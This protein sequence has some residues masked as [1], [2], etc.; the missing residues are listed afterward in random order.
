[1][2][3]EFDFIKKIRKQ[4]AIRWSQSA[5]IFGVG[6]DAAVFRKDSKTDFVITTDLLVENIDFRLE[7]T[8]PEYLGHKAL[9]V[10]LS[11]IAAMG[12]RPCFALLSIGV[13]KN[14]WKT[15]FLD[16]FY[17]GWFA[18]AEKY[19]VQLI[20]GDVSKTPDKIVVDSIVIGE[21][22]RGK[23][24]LRSTANAGDLIFVTGALGGAAAGLAEIRSPTVK[25][26]VNDRATIKER[27]L[28]QRQL[29]PNAQVEIGALLGERN[30][31]TSMIDISD[32]LSS[33]LNHLCE[34]SNVGAII[35][36]DKIPVDSSIDSDGLN[37]A[38]NGGEDF[39][40]L[41]TVNPKKNSKLKNLP[42]TQIG[43]IT[44]KPKKI[45]IKQNSRLIKLN[46]K[47]F[48]HF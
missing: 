20:G 39:E 4:S 11:D 22:K 46:P 48:I 33:D 12:A 5:I 6:D 32:G 37:L 15:K 13:P 47:G 38:L 26:G 17:K 8:R 36:A 10:S 41:F 45:F 35:D 3:S 19:N 18:L 14:I 28:I 16:S 42:V 24:V 7:W 1:M 31:A 34:E 43:L 21:T 27:L 9:A 44:D 25:E 2:R 40:L 30:L 23:A 29:R